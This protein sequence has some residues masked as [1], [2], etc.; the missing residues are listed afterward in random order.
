MKVAINGFGRIGRMTLRALQDKQGVEVVAINDLTDIGLLTHLFKY[1]TSHGKFP[2]T[3]G[4][5]D[6]RLIVNGRPI[7]LL[8]EKE[9]DKLPWA[10]LEVDVVIES[11]GR[12]TDKSKAALHLHAGAKKVLITAPATGNVKT[13]VAGVNE[14]WITEEDQILSTASCTTNCIAPILYLLEKEF[15]IE[16]GFMSTIHAFTMDQMLQDGPHKDYR[17][18]RAATQSIIPTTTGAAKAIGEVLP[19]LR[20]KL[21]GFSYRVP[22]ID[23]SIAELSLNLGRQAS[24]AE[25][26]E[27][28]Q[29]HASSSLKGILEYTEEP[30]V[31]ADILGNTHSSIV[32]GTLTR[33]IGKLV[34]V[35]AW[36][37]NEV[38]ISNRLAE[39]TVE[40]ASQDIII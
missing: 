1:D 27:F 7:L 8:S 26:N 17:R 38:G 4:Q 21:D 10:E 28:F 5:H 40:L 20:G 25:L 14:D 16:S 29:Y 35:V 24:A 12:H 2:G 22:V 23:G 13:I 19:G 9:P 18:A 31:S 34:K 11:T 3:V 6:G 39:L 30:L 32:D 15:G 36:Y 33:S 37:D